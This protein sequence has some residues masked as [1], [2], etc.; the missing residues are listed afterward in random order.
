MIQGRFVDARMSS[1]DS[2]SCFVLVGTPRL[3]DVMMFMSHKTLFIRQRLYLLESRMQCLNCSSCPA[4]CN[5][6][7]SHLIR[8][9]MSTFRICLVAS[10]LLA[11]ETI[12]FSSHHQH[13][14]GLAAPHNSHD[15]I[16]PRMVCAILLADCPRTTGSE[17]KNRAD[18]KQLNDHPDPTLSTPAPC[19]LGQSRRQCTRLL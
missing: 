9:Q 15:S 7:A 14:D 2:C 4:F 8:I 19:Y 13:H 18:A 16:L 1:T 12:I 5:I 11:L 10:Q 17:L 6:D 3:Q